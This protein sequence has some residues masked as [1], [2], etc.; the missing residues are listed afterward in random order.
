MNP[1]GGNPHRILPAGSSAVRLFV[2]LIVMTML[3]V[4]GH[5]LVEAPFM[6]RRRDR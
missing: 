3:A 2:A 5:H 1:A 6:R 4:A